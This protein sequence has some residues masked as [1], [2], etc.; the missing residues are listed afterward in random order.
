MLTLNV[1]SLWPRF[2][3]KDLRWSVSNIALLMLET[4]SYI[5]YY[6][7]IAGPHTTK[8]INT[9]KTKLRVPL[10]TFRFKNGVDIIMSHIA[11]EKPLRTAATAPPV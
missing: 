4:A 11:G 1:A 10:E 7:S 6:Q 2:S 5:Y 8:N 9:G 3:A